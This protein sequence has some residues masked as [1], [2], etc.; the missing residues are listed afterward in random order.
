M[1]YPT[2]FEWTTHNEES[3]KL[4]SFDPIFP[5]VERADPADPTKCQEIQDPRQTTRFQLYVRSIPALHTHFD[6]TKSTNYGYYCRRMAYSQELLEEVG[7]EDVQS[8]NTLG[9]VI[10]EESG[11]QAY[12]RVKGDATRTFNSSELGFSTSKDRVESFAYDQLQY[13]S[14]DVNSLDSMISGEP[15]EIAVASDYH[16]WAVLLDL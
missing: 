10:V 6:Q 13:E 15:N 11:P 4:I 5:W 7:G 8:V 1:N 14:G 16:T 12:P 2:G 3:S 9:R